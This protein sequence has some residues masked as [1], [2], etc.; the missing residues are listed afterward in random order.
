MVSE[1]SMLDPSI[2]GLGCAVVVALLV[3]VAE[4]L[5]SRRIER[6]AHLAFGVG[7]RP[8]WW[9]VVAPVVRVLSAAAV[10]WG[11]VVLA[12]L[13]PRTIEKEPTQE[14]S[15]HLLVCLDASPSMFVE[16]AGPAGKT[17]RAIW[18]VRSSKRFW[19]ASIPRQRA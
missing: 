10:V 17:K 14:A 18:A 19:I 15:K 8:R 2:L 12:L 13:P 1:P 11:L 7:G 6:V 5:H 3:A 4:T 16:D 9:V